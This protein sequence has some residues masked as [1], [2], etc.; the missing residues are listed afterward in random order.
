SSDLPGP[1]HRDAEERGQDQGDD[2]GREHDPHT[3]GLAW[4]QPQWPAVVVGVAGGA[5]EARGTGLGAQL[6]IMPDRSLTLSHP[7]P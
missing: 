4:R 1:Q 5:S 2:E 7:R 3:P 6:S